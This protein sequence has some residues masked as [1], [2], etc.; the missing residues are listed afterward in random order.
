[1]A[2]RVSN[3]TATLQA[4]LLCTSEFFSGEVTESQVLNPSSQLERE[5]EEEHLN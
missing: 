2:S 3:P 5:A 1:M 4:A